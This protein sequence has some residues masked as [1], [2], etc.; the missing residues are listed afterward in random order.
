MKQGSHSLDSTVTLMLSETL[1]S[2]GLKHPKLRPGYRS[3]SAVDVSLLA[4][5][6]VAVLCYCSGVVLS[7][8][9]PLRWP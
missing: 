4:C 1:S 3:G 9:S 6:V 7:H 5:R 2:K 8:S